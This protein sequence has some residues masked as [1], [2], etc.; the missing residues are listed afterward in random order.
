[1]RGQ[2]GFTLVELV[3]TIG[4][5]AAMVTVA[6]TVLRGARSQARVAECAANMRQIGVLLHGYA[7]DN[8]ANLPEGDTSPDRLPMPTADVF[9]TMLDG[10]I[11]PL[12]CR[13]FPQRDEHRGKW[14]SN[15][16]EGITEYEP[17]IGYVYVAGSWYDNWDVP[18]E[19]LPDDFTGAN[20]IESTG[21]GISYNGNT[22]WMADFA[23]C[24]GGEKK[25]RAKPSNWKITSH[26]AQ[27]VQDSPGRS[28]YRLPDGANVLFED[29]RVVFRSFEKLRPRLV[30]NRVYY[31]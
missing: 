14:Q 16:D 6:A 1:M 8:C 21:H 2:R 31:W 15:I 4:I 28:D 23:Q 18:N 10:R 11:D 22:V 25:A 7:Q 30:K 19:A 29:G 24:T 27:F 3:V 17:R 26:P 12:Y 20:R 13:T 9:R 5:I